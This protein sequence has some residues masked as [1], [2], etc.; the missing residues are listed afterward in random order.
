MTE[1]QPSSAPWELKWKCISFTWHVTP[2]PSGWFLILYTVIANLRPVGHILPVDLSNH[3]FFFSIIIIW[4]LFWNTVVDQTE[5]LGEL[6]VVRRP[7]VDDHWHSPVW[8]VMSQI[9]PIMSWWPR[10][11]FGQDLSPWQQIKCFI[12]CLS[13]RLKLSVWIQARF[14][15]VHICASRQMCKTSTLTETLKCPGHYHV[16]L[17]IMH[18]WRILPFVLE[19]CCTESSWTWTPRLLRLSFTFA[20]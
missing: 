7:L 15:A 11:L 13:L 8:P 1:V 12:F 4:C 2:S 19:A 6:H 20:L 5:W 9:C 18:V 10:D 14:R 16:T 3:I 17:V